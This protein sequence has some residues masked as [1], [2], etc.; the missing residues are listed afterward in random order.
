MFVDKWMH[1]N[2]EIAHLRRFDFNRR[3]DC[4]CETYSVFRRGSKTN[5]CGCQATT[6]L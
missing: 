6:H 2:D 1:G 4:R 3:K 5:G